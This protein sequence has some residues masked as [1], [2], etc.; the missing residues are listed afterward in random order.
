MVKQIKISEEEYKRL[1]AL[2][3]ADIKKTIDIKKLKICVETEIHDKGKS[4]NEINKL[5]PKGWRKLRH[6]EIIFLFNNKNYKEKLNLK[7]TWEFIETYIKDFPVS[8]FFADSVRAYL[9]CDSYPDYS[10][11]GLGV[12]W[13]RDLKENEL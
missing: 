4:W 3:K 13:V 8:R 12:R 11:V 5:I 6:D 2:D 7:D 9:Y 1:K 10:K